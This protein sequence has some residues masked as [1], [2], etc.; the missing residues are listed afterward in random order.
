[1]VHIPQEAGKDICRLPPDI[2]A[3]LLVQQQLEADIKTVVHL[4]FPDHG[5]Q[6][7]RLAVY[8]PQG[9]FP[10]LAG[11]VHLGALLR[12]ADAGFRADLQGVYFTIPVLGNELPERIVYGLLLL[13]TQKRVVIR[14]KL[15]IGETLPVMVPDKVVFDIFNRI[16]HLL[17]RS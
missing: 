9:S 4:I 12:R 10:Q 13:H 14:D 16:L 17:S 1:M 2:P 6:R 11:S 3:V 5:H 8:A 15:I 7:V